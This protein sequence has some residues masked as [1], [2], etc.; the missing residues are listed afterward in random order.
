MPCNKLGV[1]TANLAVKAADLIGCNEQV[2][3]AVRV[4]IAQALATEAANVTVISRSYALV[5]QV[6]GASF[7]LDSNGL[8]ASAAG[9]LPQASVTALTAKVA[10]A[11]M[12]VQGLIVQQK[13]RA[14]L[15]LRFRLAGEQRTPNGAIV[16]TLEV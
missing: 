16:M 6:G 4:V 9:G 7:S 14:A 11:L 15:A 5:I 13:V 12:K 1:V 10:A 2:R 8:R 3:N